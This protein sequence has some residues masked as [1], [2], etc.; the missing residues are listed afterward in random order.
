MGKP[1][2]RDN[3]SAGYQQTAWHIM[4]V[5]KS[6]DMLSI[7]NVILSEMFKNVLQGPNTSN[8]PGKH[9]TRS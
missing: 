8:L 7:V 3:K 9:L 1:V 2:F 4:D 6:R 5:F